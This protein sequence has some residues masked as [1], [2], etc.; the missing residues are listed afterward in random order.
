[1]R[2][3]HKSKILFTRT[4]DKY[5]DL[6]KT[7]AR[8]EYKRLSFSQHIVD[9]SELINIGTTAVYV[10][11]SSQ[12]DAEHNIAYIS[13]AIKWAIRN[14]FRKRFKWYSCRYL[15]KEPENENFEE[16]EE[17]NQNTIREAIYETI[18]SLDELTESDN[19]VQIEAT[20][21]TPDR[22]AE[23]L[24]ISKALRECMNELSERERTVLE[25]RFYESKRVKQIATEL[26]LT[27][28]RVSKII[29]TGLDRI[30]AK[31]KNDHLL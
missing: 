26:E 11:V 19:P 20:D 3:Y 4:V 22:R 7:V 1:M 17:S 6:I 29:Q 13:T 30:K 9:I 16:D 24:E 10:I 28:S 2:D 14:E 25:M 5:S 12:P 31:L 23:F 27:P 21:H 8:V 18:F 15:S